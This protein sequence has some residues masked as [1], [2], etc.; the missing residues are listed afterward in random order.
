MYT[1][2]SMK[3]MTWKCWTVSMLNSHHEYTFAPYVGTYCRTRFVAFQSEPA[4]KLI[5]PEKK[6]VNVPSCF[7]KQHSVHL[8]YFL[9]HDLDSFYAVEREFKA[10]SVYI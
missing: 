8:Q 6:R 5:L 7:R 1:V 9:E 2:N 4:F 10:L 3:R